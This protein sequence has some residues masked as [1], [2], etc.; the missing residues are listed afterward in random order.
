MFKNLLLVGAASLGVAVAA[1]AAAA[2]DFSGP[3]ATICHRTG[4]KLNATVFRGVVITISKSALSSHLAEHGD[5]VITPGAIKFFS[6]SKDCGVD[7]A[8]NLFDGK[9]N[10]ISPVKGGGDTGGGT[11]GGGTPPPP[12]PPVG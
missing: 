5:V 12:P 3:K 6:R 9:G 8:G 4:D 11:G 1:S 2:N 7:A 10:P